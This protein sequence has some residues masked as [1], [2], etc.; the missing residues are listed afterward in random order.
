MRNRIACSADRLSLLDPPM[1]QGVVDGNAFHLG[2]QYVS[3]NRVRIVEADELQISSA[4][5]GNSGLYEQ[6]IR[7][8]DGHLVSKCTCS[9]PEE[10]MCRHCIAVLLEYNRWVEPASNGRNSRKPSP[11]TAGSSTQI[12]GN[13]ASPSSLSVNLDFKLSDV[14]A[15]IEWQQLATKALERGAPLPDSSRL[16]GD[17]GLWTRNIRSLDERRRESEEIQQTFDAERR[18][19]ETHIAQLTQQLEASMVEVKNLDKRYRDS[20]EIQQTL[21]AERRDRETYIAQLTQQLEASMAQVSL[22]QQK[23]KQLHEEL[24]VYKEKI[25]QVTEAAAEVNGFDNQIKNIAGDLLSKGSQ[26][27]KLANS[28]REVALV[29]NAVSK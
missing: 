6:V 9:L 23:I 16:T 12:N 7:L 11:D 2:N 18:D 24:A 15:F 26:L 20:A 21:E 22:T 4:V 25:V 5:V 28:Y 3:E 14:M 19:R 27:D 1:I 17:I 13:A 8:K 10:P 29:L